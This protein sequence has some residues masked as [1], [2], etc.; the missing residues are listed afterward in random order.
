M[1][2]LLALC[3]C[4]AV[5][6]TGCLTVVSTIVLKSDGSVL[7]RDSVATNSGSLGLSGA[8]AEQFMLM[9]L[10]EKFASSAT[11]LGK[12]AKLD[13]LYSVSMDS[14][15][16]L[17]S[18]YSVPSV[19]N[20]RYRSSRAMQF[21]G[22][23]ITTPAANS[24]YYTFSLKN[25]VIT[26]KNL[27]KPSNK[28]LPTG[29]SKSA[30]DIRKDIGEALSALQGEISIVTKIYSERPIVSTTATYRD[31]QTIT[32]LNFNFRTFL[33]E[34]LK[35][36]KLLEAIEAAQPQSPQDMQQLLGML[37]ASLVMMETKPTFAI[38]LAK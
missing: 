15:M 20:L 28:N 3:F 8:E 9:G 18:E 4:V 27:A 30:N 32:L 11:D 14:T 21:L 13:T 34:V 5:V 24:D 12:G 23:E 2:L 7:V 19:S 16:T 37:P 25:N 36:D 22:D 1:K 31:N 33:D 17:V 6:N 35:N 29:G 38:T 26:V 10:K